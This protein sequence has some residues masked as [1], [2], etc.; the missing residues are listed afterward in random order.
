MLRPVPKRLQRLDRR[1]LRRMR[2][3]YHEPQIEDSVKALGM[4]GEWGVIWLA[5]GMAAAAVDGPRRRRWLRAAAVAPAAVGVNYLVKLAVRRPRPRLRRLPPLAGAP[6]ELSFPSAHATSS[7]AAATAMGRV[8][9][10]ARTP[11]YGLAAAICLTRPYL[12]MHYPS[13]VLGGAALGLLIGRLWP[14]LRGKGAEDRLIDLMV[15][16]APSPAAAARDGSAGDGRT[17]AAAETSG[18]RPAGE[19]EPGRS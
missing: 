6:S 9:P 4:A 18:D 19:G 8:A 11:L 5:I 12:G 15:S 14:G 1:L 2:T 17:R 7:L 3:R 16:A 13:D 10:G